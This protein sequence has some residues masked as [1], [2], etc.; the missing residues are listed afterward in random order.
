MSRDDYDRRL[1]GFVRSL[2]LHPVLMDIGASGELPEVWASIAPESVYVGFDPDAR[3]LS[4]TGAD[5]FLTRHV[6]NAAVVPEA[7]DGQAT[8]FLTRSP[9]CSSTLEPDHEALSS[10]LFADLFQVERTASVPAIT[11]SQ[12]LQRL[13]LDRVHWFKTDS[14]GTDLRLFRSLPE[15]VRDRVLAVDVEPGLIDAYI[16]EDM[17]VDAHAY[18]ARTG[19]WLSN[20]RIGSA[21]RM[22]ATTLHEICALDRAT[23]ES[24]VRSSPG[25]CEARY[26]R[27]IEALGNPAF[28]CEDWQ[29]AWVFAMAD[30]Q[31]GFALDLAHQYARHFDED[32]AQRL[33]A[34]LPVACIRA[35]A[36][37]PL[38]RR[39]ARSVVPSGLTRLARSVLCGKDGAAS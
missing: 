22:R 2:G 27:T 39:V 31:W 37:T 24:V 1:I 26:F 11:I 20:L 17:F 15:R 16:G 3:E 5:R 29:L 6:L 38:W 35:A 25:W 7:T 14:Q 21:V 4:E 28:R 19:Y 30:R 23:V 9:F 13:G 10:F 34:E 36:H 8:I 12:S 18:L 32:A 33:M